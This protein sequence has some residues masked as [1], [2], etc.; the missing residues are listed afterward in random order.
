MNTIHQLVNHITTDN[1]KKVYRGSFYTIVGVGG[2]LEEWVRGYNAKL[3]EAGIGKPKSWV[4]FSGRQMNER[5]ALRGDN[6]YDDNLTFLAFSLDGLHV[7]KL[8][9]FKM[10]YGDRWFDDIVQNNA[11]RGGLGDSY[12]EVQDLTN[13]EDLVF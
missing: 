8:A 3:V 10:E 2:S 13:G 9:L 4:T 5:Y 12:D 7:G 11:R 1:L 6:A